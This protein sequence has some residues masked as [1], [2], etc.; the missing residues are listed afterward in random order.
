MLNECH[1]PCRVPSTRQPPVQG[2]YLLCSG[3]EL[4]LKHNSS[5][6]AS[7]KVGWKRWFSL[8]KDGLPQKKDGFP[9][10]GRIQCSLQWSRYQIPLGSGKGCTLCTAAVPGS[11]KNWNAGTAEP[12][13]TTTH[14][15]LWNLCPG[16]E[17]CTEAVKAARSWWQMLH[18]P[19]K[20]PSS[21]ANKTR[22]C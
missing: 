22:G 14:C 9:E 16:W 4:A 2:L 19:A 11:W 18:L 12:T 6:S 3:E 17:V 1:W 8:K 20:H 21:R 10:T 15:T 7:H 5:P 13:S